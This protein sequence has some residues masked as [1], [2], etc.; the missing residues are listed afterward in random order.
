MKKTLA[1]LLVLL[2]VGFISLSTIHPVRADITGIAWIKPAWKNR[3]GFNSDPFLGDVK[4][5]YVAGETWTLNVMVYNDELNGTASDPWWTRKPMDVTVTRIAVW[6]DWNEFYNNTITDI[7]VDY[8][9]SYLF[10]VDDTTPPTSTASNLFT[11]IY[12]IY[13]DFEFTYKEGGETHTVKRTWGPWTGDEF[14]VLSQDQYDAQLAR[15]KFWNFHDR[16]HDFVDDYTESWGLMIE[17]EGEAEMAGMSYSQGE[18]SSALQSFNTAS[19]LL[20]Q[21]LAV[22]MPKETELDVI[23]RNQTKARLDRQLAENEAIRANATATRTLADATASA[24]FVNS[25]AFVFFGIGFVFFGVAAIIF[26]WKKP[27][28][29]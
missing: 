11:H 22:Y 19:N 3:T 16:V 8:G 26:A 9:T 12:K 6:F 13:V 5:A 27:K 7:T 4:V 24:M 14:A 17:A 23:T 20:N 1:V 10:T 15:E 18:F 29:A 2:L 25:L 21:S 28:P